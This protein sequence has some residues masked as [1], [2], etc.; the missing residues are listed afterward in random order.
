MTNQIQLID[1]FTKNRQIFFYFV[2]S[3]NA[4]YRR[5]HDLEYY[6]QIIEMHRTKKDLNYLLDDN[7]I[8]A[9]LHKTLEKW[10]MNQQ[11]AKLAS[12]DTIQKSILS[13]RHNLVKLYNYQLH[14]LN[15]KQVFSEVLPMI[16]NVF[17]NL[18]IMASQSKL[19]GVSKAL[20][21]LLP[22][23]VTPVDN[24][25]TLFFFK[26]SSGKNKEFNTFEDVFIKTYRITDSLLLKEND[27]DGKHWNTSI[28][29]LIDN[30]II[31]FYKFTEVNSLETV[32]SMMET[33][34]RL[35]LDEKYF[36]RKLLEDHYRKLPIRQKT[37]KQIL[38]Q[39]AKQAGITVSE[40][41]IKA[42]MAKRKQV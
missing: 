15:K 7:M 8:Y 40:E 11:G 24:K 2:N 27:F 29:K 36:L 12:V 23:L 9:L 28:P 30:A 3:C 14:C 41:E 26:K 32:L 42:E 37:K 25:Y 4:T 17:H 38:L 5:G 1:I 39:K 21:F 13:E 10:N 20:H 6:R 22:D 31:G 19:V 16:S 34:I 35:D 18:K 33:L